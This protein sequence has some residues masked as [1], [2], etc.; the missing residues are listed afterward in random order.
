M[1]DDVGPEGYSGD[2]CG[3]EGNGIGPG[4]LG[5][6]LVEDESGQ[7]KA[8][9]GLQWRG[10]YGMHHECEDWHCDQGGSKSC[11]GVNGAT[12]Q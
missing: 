7:A 6:M 1:R 3:D 2:G 11:R 12:K 5:A 8:N 4:P 10:D 9:G